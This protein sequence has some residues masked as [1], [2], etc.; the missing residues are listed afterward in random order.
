VGVTASSTAGNV[1]QLRPAASGGFAP[2]HPWDRNFFLLYVGLIWLGI[3]MGFG[4]QIVQH[5]QGLKP[6]FPLIVHFHAAAFVGWLV[7]FTGQVLLIRNSRWAIHRKLGAA[8]VGLAVVMLVLGPTTALIVD[9]LKFGTKASDPAFLSVQLTDMLAFAGL[10]TAAVVFRN[11][12]SA[13]KR[14]ILLA[15]IYI[16]DAGFARWLGGAVHQRFGDGFW[17]F[18]GGAYTGTALLMLGL[19]AYDLITR[20]RLHP[21]YAAGVGW[22]LAMELTAV[23]L[24]FNPAWKS[25][26]TALIGHGGG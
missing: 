8:M 20:R 23:G 4:P 12:A 9:G 19:G 24:Y 15:T 3:V 14:L 21:A 1:R 16:S 26:A 5:A 6:P 10:I 17:A 13:H 25:V 7:L 18:W 11:R 2:N 22:A